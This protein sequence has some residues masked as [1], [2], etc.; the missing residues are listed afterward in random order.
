MTDKETILE[1]LK[2]AGFERD[3]T[4]QEDKSLCVERGYFGFVTSFEFNDDGS[5]KDIGAYE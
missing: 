5:L 2:R 1:M 3:I 4:H